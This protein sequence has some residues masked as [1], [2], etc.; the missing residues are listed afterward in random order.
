M[1]GALDKQE[2]PAEM[3]WE[4]RRAFLALHRT[5]SYQAAAQMLGIDDST[6]RR[7]IQALESEVDVA[8][9]RS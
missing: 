9:A 3:S 4:L 8:G 6:L 5:E 1:E 2:R 7:R